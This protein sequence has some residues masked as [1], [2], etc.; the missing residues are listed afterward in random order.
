MW[1]GVV[2][3]AIAPTRLESS[4]EKMDVAVVEWVEV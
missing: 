3:F 2:C 1:S 4:A